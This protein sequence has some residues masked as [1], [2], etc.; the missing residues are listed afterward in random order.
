M[1]HNCNCFEESDPEK[2]TWESEEHFAEYAHKWAYSVRPEREQWP[3]LIEFLSI[4]PVLEIA[5][6]SG[7][8]AHLLSKELLTPWIATDDA[9]WECPQCADRKFYD[10]ERMSATDAVLKIHSETLVV[11]WPPPYVED[12]VTAVKNYK[13]Q[14][15]LYIGEWVE[16]VTVDMPFFIALNENWELVDI[17]PIQK[18]ITD[19]AC[20]LYKRKL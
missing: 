16:G 7:L 5:A 20:Y 1:T 3:K 14:Q 18:R 8:L 15:I 2:Q 9:S 17:V 13:G 6:G 12:I 10:S 11:I 4:G 19:E